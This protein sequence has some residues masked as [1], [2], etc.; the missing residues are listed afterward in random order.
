MKAA[1]G[2]L[3]RQIERPD[4]SIRL[5]LLHGADEAASR[6]LA[7]RLVAKLA[8]PSDPMS[9]TDLGP[10]VLSNDPARLADEA[11]AVSM[12]GGAR[13]LR[14]EGAGEECLEAARLLLDAPAAGNPV[15]MTAGA[16]K[17]GSKLLALV[18]GARAA[19]AHISYEPE[20]RDLAAVAAEFAAEFGL[21]PSRP[22][23]A[24]LVDACAGDR[25]VLRQEIEKLAL[26]LDASRDAPKRLEPDHL[27]AV[28]ASLGEADFGALVDAVAGGR[29]ADADR[30][31]ARL[32]ADG[33]AG[34][35]LL[36]AVARRFWLLAELR[37]AVDAGMN[38]AAAVD[39]A[40]P[41]VF[42]KE[43]AAVAAQVDRWR[44]AALRAALDRLLS[45]ERDI[46]RSG[47]AGDVI[48][49]QA[50]L[51]LATQAKRR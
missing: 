19:L 8:D 18:E 7:R 34:I 47:S 11:A 4:P 27:A 33:I 2:D 26:Y 45:A 22:A 15:V 1:K 39:A 44:S 5:Y 28:G 46:K 50:L 38:P 42:W 9:V 36:R 41:P 17:K 14:V 31:I 20:A 51:A 10:S 30:Q 35:A 6:D 24:H 12:F 25:G 16:L 3:A 40:R 21:E 37:G 49:T 32:E 29:P 23:I 48:A 13:V 43:K